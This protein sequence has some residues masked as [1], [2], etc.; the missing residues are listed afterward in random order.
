MFNLGMTELIFIAVLALILI[1]PKQLPEIARALGRFINEMKRSSES[2][3][4][5]FRQVSEP[6]KDQV[7]DIRKSVAET[8]Q[9]QPPDQAGS[10]PPASE[11]QSSQTPLSS[12]SQNSTVDDSQDKKIN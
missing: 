1:G 4:A 8:R 2:I 5:D 6:L 11:L 7:N 9:S 10:Q 3:S 12:P